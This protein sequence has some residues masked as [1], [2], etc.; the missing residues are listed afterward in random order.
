MKSLTV[1]CPA[2][3]EAEVIANFY[4]VLKKELD[5][6]TE[7]RTDVVFVVDGGKDATFEILERIAQK[8]PRV[9][10]IKLSRNFGHQIALLAGIDHAKGDAVITMDAD[11]QH[12]PSVIPKL[13]A[14]FEKDA[15]IVYTVRESTEN[16]G[17]FRRAESSVFYRLVNLISDVPIVENAS[18]FRLISQRVATIIRTKIRER[19]LFL[20]GIV[21]W[22]GFRQSHVAFTAHKRAAGHSKYS[23]SKLIQ[24]AIFGI[25]SFSKKPLRAASIVGGLFALFGFGYAIITVVQYFLGEIVQ[26]GYSTI[27]VLLSFFGGVQLIFLGIIG[28]Y[29]GG[30]FDEVKGRPQYLIESA[31]NIDV[32]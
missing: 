15:E 29:I 7:Y 5:Q 17:T 8:D 28:E 20:R 1:V 10:A 27:V 12:P 14:E 13:L 6:L 16:I 22:M 25:I 11:L 21:S 31:I 32:E 9:H 30:I 23:L 26:P 18:D 3:N 4:D 19:N 24:F 2:Y